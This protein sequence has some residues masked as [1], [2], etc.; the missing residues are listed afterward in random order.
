MVY[1]LKNKNI[2]QYSYGSTIITI[3][4]E[5]V[6]ICIFKVKLIIFQIRPMSMNVISLT[7]KLN[8]LID[9]V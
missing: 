1:V 6:L 3:A 9:N 5:V 4:I 2:R 7:N 8:F